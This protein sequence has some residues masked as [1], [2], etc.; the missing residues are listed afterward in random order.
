MMKLNRTPAPDFLNE[1]WEEWGKVWELQKKDGKTFQWRTYQGETVSEHIRRALNE[2]SKQH[3]AFC[4]AYRL[5]ASSLATIEH[6]RPKS[7]FPLLVYQ[8]ENLFLCCNAC[9]TA[10][11][12]GFNERLLKPDEPDYSFLRYFVVNYKTGEIQANPTASLIEQE[13]AD[14]TISMFDLNESDRLQDRLLTHRMYEKT[15]D[16]LDIDVFPYRFFLE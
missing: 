3:C 12:D 13:R 11:L 7:K 1:H 10:K 2:F 4:D 5:G 14:E 16:E 9:Q 8:W 6:F 15:K